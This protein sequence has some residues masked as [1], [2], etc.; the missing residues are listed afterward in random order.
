MRVALLGPFEVRDETGEPVPVPGTRLRALLVRLV[1]S[2]EH[3]VTSDALIDAVWGEE[4]PP[5]ATN[6]LQSLVSRLRRALPGAEAARL[7]L[8]PAG[9]RLAVPA[10]TTDIAQFERLVAEGRD[11]LAAGDRASAAERFAAGLALW[12]GRPFDGLTAVPF[13]EATGAR[14]TELRLR[15]I[16][17]YAELAIAVGKHAELIADVRQLTFEYPLDERLR[18]VHM[19]ALCA[20]GRRAEAL[21]SYEDLRRALAD[22]LGTDPAPALRELHAAILRGRIGGP[23][24]PAAPARPAA[25]PAVPRGNVR[26]AVTSFVG[27]DREL[28]QIGALLADAR[29]VTLIGPGGVGKTR[30]AT[31]LATDWP[32]RAGDGAWLVDLAE[33]RVAAEVPAAVLA[34][35]GLPAAG[36]DGAAAPAERLARLFEPLRDRRA[37]L[38][39]DNCEHLIDACARTAD[40]IVSVSPGVRVLATSRE[41]L[42]VVGERLYPI[43]PLAVPPPGVKATEALDVPVLRLFADR[44]AAARFGFQLTDANLPAVTEICRRLDGLPLA[45]ELACARLRTLPAEEIAARLGDRFRLL[46]GGHRTALPRHQTLLAVVEWS[47][48][49]FTEAERTL[50]RRLAVFVSGATPDAIEGVCADGQLPGGN[51]LGLL[52]ALVDRSFVDFQE[53]TGAPPRYGMLN[54][55]QSYA[56]AAL[57]DAGESDTFRRAHARWFLHR[58]EAVEPALRG[59]EQLAA[60]AWLSREQDN[61]RAALRF[62]VDTADTALA[63]RLAGALG[64]Y[65]ELRGRNAE[66]AGWLREVLALPAGPDVPAA[67]LAT[68]YA[69]DAMNHFAI[70]DPDR[71]TASAGRARELAAGAT[72]PAVL[73]IG[74][75]QH[76]ADD[77]S[78]LAALVRHPDPWLSAAGELFSGHAAR[79]RGDSTAALVHSAA[80]RD[81]F[82][83]IGDGWGVAGAVRALGAGLSLSGDHPAAIAALGEAIRFA[84]TVAAHD[85]AWLRVARG[86][87][88]L[89]AG[90]LDAASDELARASD[91]G[92][93][94]R[95]PVVLAYA[96]AALGE[97]AR[98]AGEPARAE[99]LLRAALRRSDETPGVPLPVPLLAMTG[100]ARLAV[101]DRPAE[102]R[103]LLADALSRAVAARD[104]QNHP[105]IASVVEALAEL[106]RAEGRPADAA[107]LLGYAAAGRGTPDHGSPDVRRTASAARAALGPSYDELFDP[108]AALSADAAVSAVLTL[109][110]AE[111]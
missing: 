55:I 47:W 74:A 35:L 99:T 46:T 4:P 81:K 28:A 7:E 56:A 51:V 75:I 13:A 109:T 20:A 53:S 73:L 92:H 44:A 67:A 49:L 6:A 64:W 27:R 40:A 79:V 9:Y 108:A 45:I 22:T 43:G 18:A 82:T 80:A 101:A 111:T 42:A 33:V 38:I 104:V 34:T 21:S 68:A 3:P 70:Q 91:A 24:A 100:L 2:P 63:V 1:L 26:T 83:A 58:A 110:A 66:A 39:L 12:R 32:A 69:F 98:A 85:A 50:G 15:T 72:H 105:V 54:T 95:A 36:P 62:A 11:R 102:A 41:P 31:E 23:A 94:L 71:G 76:V 57:A 87:E 5:N 90:E 103:T 107:R 19:R 84:E 65:W 16:E 14:L 61:L 77:A 17:D 30:L 8:L 59:R 25:A 93:Q 78:E 89:R 29:L 97:L 106:A 96:D 37:L 48:Q 10:D 88:F 52:G 60:L 86:M